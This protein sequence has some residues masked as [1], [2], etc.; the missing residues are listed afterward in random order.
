MAKVYLSSPVKSIVPIVSEDTST[1]TKELSKLT[2]DQITSLSNKTG[3]VINSDND[4]AEAKASVLSTLN[5]I[6]AQTREVANNTWDVVTS[7]VNPITA[8][9]SSIPGIDELT[10]ALDAG[11]ELSTLQDTAKLLCDGISFSDLNLDFLQHK[12]DFEG[13]LAWAIGA[14]DLEFLTNLLDCALFDNTS[15]DHLK[16][17]LSSLEN[18][19]SVGVYKTILPAV[20]VDNIANKTSVITNLVS[21]MEDTDSNVT[22]AKSI[23]TSLDITP[24]SLVQDTVMSTTAVDIKSVTN[25]SQK[26]IKFVDDTL[27][28]T[29]RKIV[30][31]ISA[32]V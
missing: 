20:G 16:T 1:E 19:G 30:T 8:S 26:G 2:S 12:I 15:V 11:T 28:S 9:V 3:V 32:I 17:K 24:T 29:T 18:S 14:M 21:N 31:T 7:I 5:S 10:Q 13:L 25:L 22:D 27:S 4:L 6:S 23:L